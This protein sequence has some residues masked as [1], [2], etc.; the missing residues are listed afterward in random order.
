MISSRVVLLATLVAHAICREP[1]VQ[2]EEDSVLQV[3]RAEFHAY[4]NAWSVGFSHAPDVHAFDVLVFEVCRPPCE[5]GGDGG[6]R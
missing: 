1:F 5:D 4:E 3:E 6:G 2:L